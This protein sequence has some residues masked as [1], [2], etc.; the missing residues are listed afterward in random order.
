M[1]SAAVFP[2]ADTFKCSSGATHWFLQLAFS[3]QQQEGYTSLEVE[4][5]GSSKTDLLQL[6]PLAQKCKKKKNFCCADRN[7]SVLQMAQ[8]MLC[9]DENNTD[10]NAAKTLQAETSRTEHL[11]YE[12]PQQWFW[13]RLAVP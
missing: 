13:E 12:L 7:L 6:L 3:L 10:S 4:R 9:T 8:Q 11:T 2:L 1:E 5:R